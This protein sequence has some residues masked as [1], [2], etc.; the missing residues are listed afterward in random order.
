MSHTYPRMTRTY[1]LVNVQSIACGN[2][3]ITP[4]WDGT[5]T[6]STFDEQELLDS[7]P[8]ASFVSEVA[9]VVPPLDQFYVTE[10]AVP[11][12]RTRTYQIAADAMGRGVDCMTYSGMGWGSVHVQAGPGI[13]KTADRQIQ[14]ALYS[15]PNVTMIADVPTT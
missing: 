3:W 15:Y 14:V 12:G 7:Y 10:Q 6:T 8:G 9:W 2:S 4:A 13:F 11:A 1:R 5:Y